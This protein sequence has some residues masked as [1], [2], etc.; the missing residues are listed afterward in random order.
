MWSKFWVMSNSN[1]KFELRTYPHLPH[2]VLIA[3]KLPIFATNWTVC[4]FFG[5]KDRY[6]FPFPSISSSNSTCQLT[7][8]GGV[9]GDELNDEELGPHRVPHRDRNETED[10]ASVTALMREDDFEGEEHPCGSQRWRRLG[11]DCGREPRKDSRRLCTG[12]IFCDQE[13]STSA[14]NTSGS[15]IEYCTDFRH[16]MPRSHAK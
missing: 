2:G 4:E 16:K 14:A 1:D 12:S 11:K 8:K 5:S 10:G 3:R 6:L 15:Y 9:R 13:K 7:N